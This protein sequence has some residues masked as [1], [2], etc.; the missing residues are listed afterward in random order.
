MLAQELH[1]FRSL[2]RKNGILFAYS[3]FVSESVLSGVGEALKQKL[4]IEDTDTKTLRSVFAVFVEQMQNIIR[5]SAEKDRQDI[6]EGLRYGVLTVGEKDGQY[7][8]H[9]G[10]L[11]EKSDAGRLREKLERVQSMDKDALKAAYKEQ[12]R[13]GPDETSKGAGVGIIEIAR[14]ASEPIDFDILDVDDSHAF[15]ALIAAIG[16][17]EKQR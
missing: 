5:Y 9:A 3:G 8:V 1:D 17:G 14:R 6:D 4:S 15:F 12:L 16:K 13:A 7:V 10:N 2:L 11:I